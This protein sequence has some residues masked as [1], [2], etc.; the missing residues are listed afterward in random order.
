[1]N[2]LKHP[3]NRNSA[4]HPLELIKVGKVKNG[5]LYIPLREWVA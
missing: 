2:S 3:E 5:K 4:R 1:M